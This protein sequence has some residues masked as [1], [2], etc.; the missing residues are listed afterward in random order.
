[1]PLQI[2]FTTIISDGFSS[3]FPDYNDF[4]EFDPISLEWSKIPNSDAAPSARAYFGFTSITERLFVLGGIGPA[5][6]NLSVFRIALVI[7][8]I[9][10]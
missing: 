1:L 8:Y 4:F 9:A 3:L 10:G 6:E 7:C 5:G 2:P